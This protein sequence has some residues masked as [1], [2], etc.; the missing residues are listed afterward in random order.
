VI[1]ASIIGVILAMTKLKSHCVI[2]DA[3]MINDRT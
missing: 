2:S 3:A 1:S